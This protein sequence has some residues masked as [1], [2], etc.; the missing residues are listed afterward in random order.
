MKRID[1]DEL[2]PLLGM[3]REQARK[4]KELGELFGTDIRAVT[5]AVREL[6]EGG[7][8]VAASTDRTEGGYYIT[9]TRE[10]AEQYILFMKSHIIELAKRM[11]DYKRAARSIMNPG[12]LPL[13]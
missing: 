10:E 11:R 7:D 6:I 4:A 1:P 2:I 5:I 3:G 8:P 13:I 12:Q 9:A